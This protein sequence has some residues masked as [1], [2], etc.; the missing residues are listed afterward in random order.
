MRTK[1]KCPKCGDGMTKLYFRHAPHFVPWGFMCYGCGLL[2][3]DELLNPARLVFLRV[4][5]EMKKY[6]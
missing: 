5:E 2:W 1:K 6:A 4:E 3:D